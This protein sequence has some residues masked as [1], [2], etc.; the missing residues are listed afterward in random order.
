MENN[1]WKIKLVNPAQKYG[2]GN[3]TWGQLWH[4]FSIALLVSSLSRNYQLIFFF[5]R[6]FTFLPPCT[7]QWHQRTKTC[8]INL[9]WPHCLY[10][11]FPNQLSQ[12]ILWISLQ[13][14][15][16]FNLLSLRPPVTHGEHYFVHPLYGSSVY[17]PPTLST[18]L[19]KYS[20]WALIIDS[21]KVLCWAFPS[22]NFPHR[23][24]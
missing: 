16:N 1:S 8:I 2:G 13:R 22:Q 11:L 24:M 21:Y 17:V 5:L 6:N 12:V 14:Q 15:S 10:S 3:S 9:F 7:S 19:S 18:S 20:Y 4:L 23:T